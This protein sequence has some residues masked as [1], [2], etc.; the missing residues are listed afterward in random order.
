LIPDFHE[1]MKRSLC[2]K[3]PSVMGVV[4]NVYYDEM[5]KPGSHKFKDLASSFA[6]ILKQIIEH[7]LAKGTHFI[8]YPASI[9]LLSFRL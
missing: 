4:L 1:K 6:V 5:K 3:D 9:T 8:F 7:K 2:D